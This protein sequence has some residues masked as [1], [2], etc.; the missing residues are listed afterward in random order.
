MPVNRVQCY[1]GRQTGSYQLLA[2]P[3]GEKVRAR[4]GGEGGRETKTTLEGLSHA[5]PAITHIPA[6]RLLPGWPHQP[7]VRAQE[8]CGI[9]GHQRGGKGSGCKS[10]G[11]S[12]LDPWWD[13][14]GQL[15]TR[16]SWPPQGLMKVPRESMG[17]GCG[18][19][20][21]V[22]QSSPSFDNLAPALLLPWGK[23]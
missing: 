19:S 14:R 8:P 21:G 7:C 22:M 18:Q 11:S 3:R 10:G 23:M 1:S 6:P 13:T 17:A 20:L 9:Q 2:F 15:G 12:M 5:W 4:L 16:W